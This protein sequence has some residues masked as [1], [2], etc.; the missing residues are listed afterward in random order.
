MKYRDRTD[1][2]AKILQL[3]S[4][5]PV[6]KTRLMY[7]AFLPHEYMKSLIP[8]LVENDL[9]GFDK[10]T[11]QFH[12]TPKGLRYLELYTGMQQCLHFLLVEEVELSKKR[13]YWKNELR[14][15]GIEPKAKKNHELNDPDELKNL[16]DALKLSMYQDY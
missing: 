15:L 4:D 7:M 5:R 2:V 16:A 14:S 6:T 9:L 1:I 8:I 3:A 13:S 10:Q 12:T 11:H